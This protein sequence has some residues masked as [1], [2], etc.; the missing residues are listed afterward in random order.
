MKRTILT[1]LALLAAALPAPAM[2]VR[3]ASRPQSVAAA[4][5]VIVGK[6]VAIES[7]TVSATPAPAAKDKVEYTIASVKIEDAL[8]GAKGL[9]HIKVGFILPKEQPAPQPG[10]PARPMIRRPPQAKLEVD[11]EACLLLKKH[12]DGEFYVMPTFADVIDKKSP[13]FEK[14]VA[15]VKKCAKL[16]ADPKASLQSKDAD[17]RTLTAGMLVMRYRAAFVSDGKT[18][19]IDADE[20]KLIL[21]ALAEGDWSKPFAQDTIT[22][23]A[24]FGRLNLAEKDGFV[25]RPGPG[26]PPTA[27]RDMAKAWLKEHADTYRIRRFVE[28]KKDK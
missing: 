4:D 13:N 26:T 11:R 8:L 28:E 15:L 3:P 24:A 22:P 21:K 6:V 9:T 10:G 20:S 16:L 18:E 17:E 7:K 1:G 12:H 19:P 14:D 2:M 5:A 23:E 27:Y 25:W